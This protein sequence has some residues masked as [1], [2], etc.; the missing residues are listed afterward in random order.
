M[1]MRWI[2]ALLLLLSCAARAGEPELL[3][4]EKAFRFSARLLDASQIELPEGEAAA[5]G[6]PAEAVAH[7]EFLFIHPVGTT[8]DKGIGSISSN[9]TNGAAG[10]IFDKEIVRADISHARAIGREFGETQG[11]RGRI[12]T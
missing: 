5:V 9:L 7:I 12:T 6:R 8:V 1:L 11:R 3:E 10:Q 2:L 4:P